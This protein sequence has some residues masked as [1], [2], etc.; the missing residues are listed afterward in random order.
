MDLAIEQ[1]GVV[2]DKDLHHAGPE[3]DHAFKKRKS[4][5]WK[6]THQVDLPG[7]SGRTRCKPHVLTMLNAVESIYDTVVPYD[8]SSSAYE[9]LCETGVVKIPKSFT[10]NTKRLY[11]HC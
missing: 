7:S 2:I 3:V 8:I 11:V 6:C 10:K 5:C 4:M 1:R 9:M